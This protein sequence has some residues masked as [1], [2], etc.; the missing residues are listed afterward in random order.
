MTN[1]K[2]ISVVGVSIQIIPKKYS[3]FNII[4]SWCNIMQFEH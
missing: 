1:I 3:T 4:V 2:Y